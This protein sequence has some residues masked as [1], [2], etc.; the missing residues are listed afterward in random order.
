[1]NK[2]PQA[3]DDE[4]HKVVEELNVQNHGLVA[5]C[6]R[7]SVPHKT[8]Q[9]DGLITHLQGQDRFIFIIIILSNLYLNQEIP[10]RGQKT[11]FTSETSPLMEWEV[12]LYLKYP[13]IMLYNLL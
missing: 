1:M 4:V 3:T 11:S 13:A 12:T 6:E 2:D 5:P 10:H 7:P 8:H 9:E